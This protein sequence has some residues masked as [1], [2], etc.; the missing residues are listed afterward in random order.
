MIKRVT[1]SHTFTLWREA[2]RES[3]KEVGVTNGVIYQNIFLSRCH[4]YKT[5]EPFYTYQSEA[6]RSQQHADCS[7]LNI[8][9]F[10]MINQ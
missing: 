4:K 8:A 7:D 2:K 10:N 5:S 1:V 6:I 3:R 9:I